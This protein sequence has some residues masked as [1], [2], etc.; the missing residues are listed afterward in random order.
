MGVLTKLLYKPL[1]NVLDKRAKE[2]EDAVLRAEEAGK[3]AEALSDEAKKAFNM[4]KEEA[5]DLAE[6]FHRVVLPK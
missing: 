3:K 1:M 6:G 2:I 4:A 5:F